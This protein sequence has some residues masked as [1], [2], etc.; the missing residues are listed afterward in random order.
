MITK[1]NRPYHKEFTMDNKLIDHYDRKYRNTDS[2]A[3]KIIPVVPKPKDRFEMAVLMAAQGKGKYL[4]IGAGSGN[5]VLSVLEKY[6]EFVLTELSRTRAEKLTELFKSSK[7]VKVL[8]HN[9]E[10]DLLNYPDNY[11]DVAVL[12]DVIEHLFDP[13]SAVTKIY[14]LL[15]PGGCL[16]MGTPNIAKYT[17]RIKL[18]FGF[19]PSTASLSEGLLQYDKKTPTDLFDEGHLH[20]FTYSSLSR[21]CTEKCGFSHV[22]RIGYGA[23]KT[24]KAPY[25]LGK[26]LPT[27]FSEIFIIAKK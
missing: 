8:Q 12:I 14:H 23:W 11:F 15:K 18:L 2:S 4:E 25:F 27:L 26:N 3:V 6:H 20:Y 13:I 17:R 7:K 5:I 21:L 16:I 24:V 10:T 19:F 1:K 9:I 22:D